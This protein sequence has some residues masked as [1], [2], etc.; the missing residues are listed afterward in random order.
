MKDPQNQARPTFDK[1]HE[2][3]P[4]TFL[5]RLKAARSYDTKQRK[6]EERHGLAPGHRR[7]PVVIRSI[8]IYIPDE[9]A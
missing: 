9:A 2:S 4:E 7:E 5:N 3:A 8:A 6:Q 1:V